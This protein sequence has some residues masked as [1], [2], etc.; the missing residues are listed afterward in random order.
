M[1]IIA[2]EGV[3]RIAAIRQFYFIDVDVQPFIREYC[4]AFALKPRAE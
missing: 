3:F 4:A 1:S 2:D